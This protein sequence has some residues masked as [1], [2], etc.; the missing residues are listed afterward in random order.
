MVLQRRSSLDDTDPHIIAAAIAAY[1]ANNKYRLQRD[2]LPL[3]PAI[4]FPAIALTNTSRFISCLGIPF[5]IQEMQ[6]LP[7]HLIW[8]I[9][10]KLSCHESDKGRVRGRRKIIGA[11]EFLFRLSNYFDIVCG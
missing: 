9:S 3:P 7:L 8:R 5:Q 6:Q 1:T 11:E 2:H 10:S 4:T